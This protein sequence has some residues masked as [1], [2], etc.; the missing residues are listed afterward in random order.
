VP[1]LTLTVGLILALC[2]SCSCI[3]TALCVISR[4]SRPLL[5]AETRRASK[6]VHVL[7]TVQADWTSRL[8]VTHI[9]HGW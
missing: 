2:G 6:L 7:A 8:G 4:R 1:G 3:V 5:E 9:C